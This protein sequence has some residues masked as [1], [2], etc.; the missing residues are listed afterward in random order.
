MERIEFSKRFAL[1]R[2]G[3]GVILIADG[4]PIMMFSDK[5]AEA[6]RE[7]LG[8]FYRTVHKQ[9]EVE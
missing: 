1:E 5:E 4:H 8:W 7:A 3:E 6:L 2:E 9:I